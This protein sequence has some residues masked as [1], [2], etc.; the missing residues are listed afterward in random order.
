M[1]LLERDD[2]TIIRQRGA[3]CTRGCGGDGPG[4]GEGELSHHPS[5]D[6]RDEVRGVADVRS[7]MS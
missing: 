1:L 6:V 3:R 5:L 7:L 2:L 4:N